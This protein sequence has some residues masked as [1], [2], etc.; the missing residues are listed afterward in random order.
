MLYSGGTDLFVQRGL[1]N[2]AVI[3]YSS[4]IEY[5]PTYPD[6][7]D[8][9]SRKTVVIHTGGRTVAAMKQAN[10]IQVYVTGSDEQIRLLIARSLPLEENA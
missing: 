6:T 4:R 3:M 9:E 7:H 2:A 10:T 8:K 1:Q 5:Q